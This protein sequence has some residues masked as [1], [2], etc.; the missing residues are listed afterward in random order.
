VGRRGLCSY[1]LIG[2]WYEDEAKAIAGQKAFIVNRIGDFGF[3]IGI[4]TLFLFTGQL[5]FYGMR[6]WM[7]DPRTRSS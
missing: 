7:A 2:F 1:L 5:D 3:L 4:F 6:A